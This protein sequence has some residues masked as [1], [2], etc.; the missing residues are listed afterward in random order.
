ML[1]SRRN[2]REIIRCSLVG[3]QMTLFK[4]LPRRKKEK[5]HETAT[6]TVLH[7]KGDRRNR[8]ET[9]SWNKIK[10]KQIMRTQ[11]ERNAVAKAFYLFRIHRHF[12]CYSFSFTS[13]FSFSFV[14]LV[15]FFFPVVPLPFPLLS[16]R[17]FFVSF[18]LTH[19]NYLHSRAAPWFE[20]NLPIISRSLPFDC[21]ALVLFLAL[22]STARTAS[23]ARFT[24]SLASQHHNR[25]GSEC[26]LATSAISTRDC[27]I[28]V[29]DSGSRFINRQA[30]KQIT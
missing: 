9:E 28:S 7:S 29:G 10:Q 12:I 13:F 3:C 19:Y 11:F 1:S 4:T 22:V 25:F 15:L 8:G 21:V 23:K 6:R 5:R 24:F 30:A 26:L 14:S 17:L 18:F 16:I 2:D 20:F 27:L